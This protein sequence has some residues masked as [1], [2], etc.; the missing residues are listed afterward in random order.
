MMDAASIAR[1]TKSV[2]AGSGWLIRCP[3]PAH[4]DLTPS[5]SITDSDKG[6][7]FHCHSGCRWEDVRDGAR[8]RGWLPEHRRAEAV[9]PETARKRLAD[10]HEAARFRSQQEKAE[11]TRRIALASRIWTAS[12][13]AHGTPADVYLRH[14]GITIRPPASLRFSPNVFH[15]YERVALPAMVACIEHPVT[16]NFQAVHLTFLRGDGRG[17][18]N[19]CPAKI[20]RGKAGGG[21]VRLAPVSQHT[22][23]AEGRRRRLR[24]LNCAPAES[25]KVLWWWS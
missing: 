12:V 24:D 1:S 9:D 22:A 7:L 3:A 8:A 23:V 20:M 17:K 4:E 5:C 10:A 19:V 21:V 11:E 25:W 15:P 2:K 18:A 6:V 13:E 16:G 14:R